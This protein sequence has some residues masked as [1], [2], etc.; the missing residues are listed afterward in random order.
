MM[1]WIILSITI[2]VLIWFQF[3][4]PMN[5]FT[6]MGVK[7]LK[8]WSILGDQWKPLFRQM[9]ILESIEYYYNMFPGTQ[10][11]GFYQ[12]TIPTL[13]IKNPQLLKQLTVRDFDHF[14]DHRTFVDADVYARGPTICRFNELM[15]QP[16]GFAAVT[17]PMRSGW[18]TKGHFSDVLSPR[19]PKRC[20]IE[21]EIDVKAK[22]SSHL[23]TFI[24]SIRQRNI[25]RNRTKSITRTTDMK[26]LRAKRGE[27][28]EK[29]MQS[30]IIREELEVQDIRQ[31]RSKNGLH[32]ETGRRG[33]IDR[34]H[35]VSYYRRLCETS[36]N[37]LGMMGKH[38]RLKIN[39]KL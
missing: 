23:Q 9:S 17:V 28:L 36:L 10:Y 1:L 14:T 19:V 31:P 4:K 6:K 2:A 34:K 13:V 12:F 5:H 8:P 39:Q 25:S 21:K 26:V 7:Q 37:G 11:S 32:S 18:R 15:N 30:D 27:T 3:L 33:K 20:D 24:R 35:G 22:Q 16:I 29:R 38:H